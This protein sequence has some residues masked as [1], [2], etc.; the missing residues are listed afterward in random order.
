MKHRVDNGAVRPLIVVGVVAAQHHPQPNPEAS[1]PAVL[2]W[3]WNLDVDGLETRYLRP[4]TFLSSS[5]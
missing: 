3:I 5:W 2:N 4:D 1:V